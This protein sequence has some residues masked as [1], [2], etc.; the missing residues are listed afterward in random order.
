VAREWVPCD[1]GVTRR[2]ERALKM[3][4]GAARSAPTPGWAGVA[5]A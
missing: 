1:S 3:P 5:L 4:G 2:H